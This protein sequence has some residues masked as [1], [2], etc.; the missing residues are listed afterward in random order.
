MNCSVSPRSRNILLMRGEPRL[1]SVLNSPRKPS[2]KIEF[3]YIWGNVSGSAAVRS[4]KRSST[5]HTF[6]P[7][8]ISLCFV[9]KE[10]R[11]PFCNVDAD[12]NS[13]VSV[14]WL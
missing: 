7:L 8:G 4:P 3:M 11:P 14:N 1:P 10:S 13:P 2:V 12:V 5:V 6:S 9:P